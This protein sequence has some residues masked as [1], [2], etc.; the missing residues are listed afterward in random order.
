MTSKTA[1]KRATKAPTTKRARPAAKKT[2][3][4]A[5]AERKPRKQTDAPK[6]VIRSNVPPPTSKPSFRE[7]VD[8]LKPGNSFTV[9]I[10]Y[11]PG[12]RNAASSA[13]KRWASEGRKYRVH[14]LRDDPSKVGL[15]RLT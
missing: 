10:E 8:R 11:W 4:K 5:R 12:L 1:K 3:K 6:I 15:W 14:R 13:N 9:S 7:Q 2:T